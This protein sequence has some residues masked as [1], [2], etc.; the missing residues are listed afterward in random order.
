M[1]ADEDRGEPRLC[2]AVGERLRPLATSARTCAA[3]ALPSMIVAAWE[4][5]YP[6][7]REPRPTVGQCRKCRRPV[8]T[9]AIP[10]DSAT[11]RTSSP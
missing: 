4:E 11:D 5:S 8:T 2:T 1:V 10:R 3:I 9:T 6:P 7:C